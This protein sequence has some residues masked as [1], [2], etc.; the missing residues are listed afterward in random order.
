MGEA[1]PLMGVDW[2]R[3]LGG[4][5]SDFVLRLRVALAKRG[6]LVAFMFG[7]SVVRRA[8]WAPLLKDEERAKLAAVAAVAVELSSAAAR[9][10]RACA[11]MPGP[12]D[13]LGGRAAGLLGV[14]ADVM[15][16]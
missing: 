11:S 9:S 3:S 12:I 14:G 1:V 5:C 7:A 16:L 2:E 6:S 4:G 10:A 15:E 13:F 8:F